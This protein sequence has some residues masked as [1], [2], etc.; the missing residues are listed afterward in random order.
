MKIITTMAWNTKN[1][2]LARSEEE[3]ARSD[4]EPPK[5]RK[6]KSNKKGKKDKKIKKN[7]E[8]INSAE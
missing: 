5:P 6:K 4:E 7:Y 1:L 3:K 8:K 2:N